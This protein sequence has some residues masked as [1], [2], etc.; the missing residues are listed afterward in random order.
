MKLFLLIILFSIKGYGQDTLEFHT[1]KY[2]LGVQSYIIQSSLDGNVWNDYKNPIIPKQ[3]ENE[4]IYKIVINKGMFYRIK[5]IM[6]ND[7]LFTSPFVKDNSIPELKIQPNSSKNIPL[8]ISIK[9]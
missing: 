3:I 8:I 2:D 5:C 4:A 6:L 7:S 1:V 9:L